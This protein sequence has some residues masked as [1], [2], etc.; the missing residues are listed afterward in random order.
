MYKVGDKVKVI[1]D[2]R[3]VF[4]IR[5]EMEGEVIKIT[6]TGMLRIKAENQDPVTGKVTTY[7]EL[8]YC[9]GDCKGWNTLW[10]EPIEMP[11]EAK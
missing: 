2:A 3:P 8:F 11:K 4:N 5:H 10:F 9:N 7:N 1:Y 6:P